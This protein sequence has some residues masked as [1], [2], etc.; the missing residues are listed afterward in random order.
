MSDS[1]FPDQTQYLSEVQIRD[2]VKE[3]I[4]NQL[5]NNKNQN[6][7][8]FSDLNNKI[9]SSEIPETGKIKAKEVVDLMRTGGEM[10]ILAERAAEY[11]DWLIKFPWKKQITPLNRLDEI[12][13]R[14][15]NLFYGHED[16]INYVL[17]HAAAYYF[18]NKNAP[19]FR[20][21]FIGPPGTGKTYIAKCIANALRLNYTVATMGGASDASWVK[22]IPRHYAGS[23][24]GRIIRGLCDAGC[25]NPVFI[26][27]EID[28]VGHRPDCGSPAEALLDAVDPDC[29]DSFE[30]YYLEIPVDI[31]SVLFIAIANDLNRIHP[32]FINRF[33][34]YHF[35]EY[36]LDEKFEIAK[37]Y[38]WPKVVTEM[39]LNP[40]NVKLSDPA[41]G[42][43]LELIHE[44]EP[45]VRKLK[46][47]LNQIIK[48]II[49]ECHKKSMQNESKSS[50]SNIKLLSNVK[51]HI[52][53][54][55]LH[56]YFIYS[57]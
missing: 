39:G 56:N 4:G 25:C 3:E 23:Q 6:I 5:G 13:N 20:L 9:D 7:N 15:K 55:N 36:Q 49:R 53:R 26:I 44:D 43:I 19:P 22:G 38:I 16:I 40:A 51:C 45:G 14:L 57:D 46:R 21:C 8:V 10:G 12:E 33:Q 27:D 18:L 28:K 37:K 41:L 32:T 48:R 35:Q 52:T 2:I 31:R 29:S 34:V 30:D 50:E 42:V 47:A 24:P 17:D 11:I 54:N 1:P